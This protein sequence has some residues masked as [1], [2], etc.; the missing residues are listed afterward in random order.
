MF[1]LIAALGILVAI[2]VVVVVVWVWTI[3]KA[4]E[5]ETQVM[6]DNREDE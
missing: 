2:I 1:Y 6:R 4:I 3:H 5:S